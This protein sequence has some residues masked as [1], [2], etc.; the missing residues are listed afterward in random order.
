MC[1]SD[2]P[3]FTCSVLFIFIYLFALYCGSWQLAE[4]FPGQS[5]QANF[6]IVATATDGT[7]VTSPSSPLKPFSVALN[8][9]LAT[10]YGAY[11][12]NFQ[13]YWTLKAAGV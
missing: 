1:E 12:F 2:A 6:V 9:S 13:S 10:Q 5:N 8:E 7:V 4:Q 11:I 3:A